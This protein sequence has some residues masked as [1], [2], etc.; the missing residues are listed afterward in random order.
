M[1]WLFPNTRGALC[2]RAPEMAIAAAMI[3]E[4]SLLILF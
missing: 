1:A 2:A 4:N 3:V